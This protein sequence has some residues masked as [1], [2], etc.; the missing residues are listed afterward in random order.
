M[1]M[2]LIALATTATLFAADNFTTP[3]T[4]ARRPKI[5]PAE[6]KSSRW[7]FSGDF[8]YWTPEM[9]G[10]KFANRSIPSKNEVYDEKTQETVVQITHETKGLEV[11]GNWEPG[12]RLSMGYLF[13]EKG[14]DAAL[15]WTYFRNEP[16]KAASKKGEESLSPTVATKSFFNSADAVKGKWYLLQNTADLEVGKN[17]PVG[18][19][20]LARPFCGLKGLSLRNKTVFQYHYQ[21]NTYLRTAE[22]STKSNFMGAG[23]R[24]GGNVAYEFGRGLGI[25][26]LGSASLLYG[27][28]DTTFNGSAE[29][30][31][32]LRTVTTMQIQMGGQWKTTFGKK[33]HLGFLAAWEQ[34]FYSKV[35]RAVRQLEPSRDKS[36]HKDNGDLILK[37]LTAS[38]HLDF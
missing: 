4:T 19:F 16:S 32:A 13:D 22:V 10:L 20:F 11:E 34:N 2:V 33:Y 1:K 28:F 18:K 30:N 26:A 24:V 5:L 27:E 14:W 25:F 36:F 21:I 12:V 8:L 38:C 9:E 7:L 23:P 17:Y 35:N 3:N 6:T 37:G 29:R 15:H 31:K